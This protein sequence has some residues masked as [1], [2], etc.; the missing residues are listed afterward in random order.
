MF[1]ITVGNF[2]HK[3][4]IFEFHFNL[5]ENRIK[6]KNLDNATYFLLS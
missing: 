3:M 1:Y 2:N 4:S 6:K 5:A